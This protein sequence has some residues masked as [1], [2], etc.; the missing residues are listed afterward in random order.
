MKA[1]PVSILEVC[2]EGVDGSAHALCECVGRGGPHHC[3]WC[4]LDFIADSA[5]AEAVVLAFGEVESGAA[6]AF[7]AEDGLGG[8]EGVGEAEKDL[9]GAVAA[10][11][12]AERA[13]AAGDVARTAFAGDDVMGRLDAPLHTVVHAHAESVGEAEAKISTGKWGDKLD[14]IE[15]IAAE[16]RRQ[17]QTEGWSAAH[18]DGHVSG[19][20][21]DAAA[22]YANPQFTD[23]PRVISPDNWPWTAEW[24]KPSVDYRNQYIR[25]SVLHGHVQ[26]KIRDLAKAG[27]L[28]AA[29]IDRLQRLTGGCIVMKLCSLTDEELRVYVRNHWRSAVWAGAPETVQGTA[30]GISDAIEELI[31]RRAKDGHGSGRIE[32]RI[33]T[34]EGGEA[35]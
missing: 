1:E 6:G 34:D 9:A 33:G 2:D 11:L 18:D 29:E 19:E 23:D 13:A 8:G 3:R 27:A 31:A 26:G 15:L 12:P 20:L 7:A 21:R 22:C 28:L 24:W 10:E 16:R 35:L 5:L 30:S 25:N 4:W 32:T 14:G 17:V